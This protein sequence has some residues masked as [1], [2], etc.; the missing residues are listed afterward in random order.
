MDEQKTAR[1]ADNTEELLGAFR[2]AWAAAF[3]DAPRE[4]EEAASE[5]DADAGAQEPADK[6]QATLQ[7]TAYGDYIAQVPLGDGQYATI[8]VQQTAPKTSFDAGADRAAARRSRRVL[9]AR[10]LGRALLS[11]LAMAAIALAASVIGTSV[12]NDITIREAFD[13]LFGNFF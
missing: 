13:V 10:F 4:C 6:I 9:S 5:S 12:V 8:G 2:P 7:K 1:L 3:D 11:I